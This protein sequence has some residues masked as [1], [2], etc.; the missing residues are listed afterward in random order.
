MNTLNTPDRLSLD[1]YADPSRAASATYSSFT[2]NLGVSI[3]N[4]KQ[5]HLLRATIPIV[6]LQ[7]PDY[8][9]VFYY[10][11]LPDATTVPT[12]SHLKAVRLVPSDYVPAAGFTSF[13]RNTFFTDPSA[14]VA[15]LNTAAS[16]GGDSVT[17]NT[18]WVSGGVTFAY[19]TTTK[20][21]T[22]YGNTGSKYYANAGWNDPIVQASQADATKITT[23]N[24]G[25]STTI[26]PYVLGTTLNQRCG[27]ALSGTCTPP[28]SFG[29]AVANSIANLTGIA[30]V[31]GSSGVV[32]VDSYPNLVFTQNI[33][34]YSTLVGNQGLANY[35]RKNLVAV[36]AVDVLPFGVVQF[37]GS[38]NGGE[39]HPIPDE[40]YAVNIEMRDDNNVPFVLP[41]SANVNLELAID[42]GLPPYL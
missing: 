2:N 6:K 15:A 30:K 35:G 21:I 39:A 16:A 23:Y 33:Y 18:L 3:L 29:A 24:F 8:Q 41:L 11:E 42:Y 25:G 40:I 36:I 10:Y 13:T 7:I 22:W 12:A 5:L 20:Q 9:L 1:A 31:T 4:A 38:Y 32:P 14:L 34:L 17:Y 37:I 19:S 28:Q 26:Q 27:Y